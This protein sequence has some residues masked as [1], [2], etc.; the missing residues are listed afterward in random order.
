ML[1]IETN[2]HSGQQYNLL[3]EHLSSSSGCHQHNDTF[4][5]NY[6]SNRDNIPTYKVNIHMNFFDVQHSLPILFLPHEIVSYSH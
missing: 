5:R 3:V 6:T 4:N 1:K 2:C